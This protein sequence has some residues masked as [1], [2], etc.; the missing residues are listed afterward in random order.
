M[1]RNEPP[2]GDAEDHRPSPGSR[3][4]HALFLGFARA[5]SYIRL[6][7]GIP[8]Q[9]SKMPSDMGLRHAKIA[10]APGAAT[11]DVKAIAGPDRR[12][13]GRRAPQFLARH[14]REH[15]RRIAVLR[16]KRTSAESRSRCCRTCGARRSAPAGPS[17][18]TIAGGRDGDAPSRAAR[19]IPAQSPS[20][21][22]GLAA[23][24]QPGDP[25][26][27]RR[28]H[29]PASRRRSRAAASSVPVSRRARCARQ[30]VYL[31][32]EA[33]PATGA[34][35][36]GQAST[37]RTGWRWASTTSRCRSCGAP[38]TCACVREICEAWGR[39][40]PV[41]AKI[42]TPDAVENLEAS[43][44]ASDGVMVAR[45]DLGVEFPPERVPGHPAADHRAC[46][47]RSSAR[48]SSRPRC[49]SR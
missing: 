30:G 45:G 37:W 23:D 48:S 29:R 38:T 24:L 4:I 28:P 41:I 8:V 5:Q 20:N 31:P 40:T 7:I 17:P 6:C 47:R 19:R 11:D 27:R 26:H 39:P 22:Q 35:R 18:R 33:R 10:C 1:K 15:A 13:D 49:S 12:G 44:R 43:S 34:D 36:E 14:A 21:T 2:V 46:A 16:A 3:R 42:E 25:C 9:F 32:V